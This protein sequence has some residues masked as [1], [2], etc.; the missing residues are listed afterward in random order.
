MEDGVN[1]CESW[2]QVNLLG[3]SLCFN[4]RRLEI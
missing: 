2:L 1:Y 3:F 4:R